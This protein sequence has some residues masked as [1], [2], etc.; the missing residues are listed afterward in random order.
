LSFYCNPRSNGK[1]QPHHQLGIN[2][3]KKTRHEKRMM[4]KNRER[5]RIR[6]LAGSS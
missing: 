4:E 2:P 1:T 5:P 3:T 6:G